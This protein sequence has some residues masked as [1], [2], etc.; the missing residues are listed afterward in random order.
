MPESL[1]IFWGIRLLL[2]SVY[3]IQAVCSCFRLLRQMMPC[4]FILDR[5]SAGS[6][7]AKTRSSRR[8]AWSSD[9]VTRNSEE[10]LLSMPANDDPNAVAAPPPNYK[11]VRAIVIILGVLILLAFV[12]LIW[13][14]IAK[15]TGHDPSAPA[16]TPDFILP[17]GSKVVSVQVSTNSRLILAVQTPTGGEIEIFDTDTGK[18]VTR[19]RGPVASPTK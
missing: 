17:A 15:L 5:E 8:P 4:A 12:A 7:S 14:F 1:A 9:T 16:Q 13:G 10:S 3:M 19:I 11:L 18:L 6:A 2:S